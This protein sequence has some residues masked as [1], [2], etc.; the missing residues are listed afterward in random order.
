MSAGAELPEG[1]EWNEL[2]RVARAEVQGVI[3]SLPAPL[4]AQA[5]TLP[6]TYEHVPGDDLI[7]DGIDSDTLGLFVG[8]SYAEEDIT[9]SP[10]PPQIILFLD[11]LWDEAEGDPDFFKEEIRITVLHELGHFLGLDEDDLFDRGLE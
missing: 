10:I 3:K 7:D 4:R 5:S 9:P 8:P 6:V 1:P 2:V 11:N